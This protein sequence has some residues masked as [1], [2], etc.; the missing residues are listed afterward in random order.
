MSIIGKG[1]RDGPWYL[2]EHSVVRNDGQVD[3]LGRT[4]WAEWSHTGDLLFAMDG[5]IYRAQLKNSTLAPSEEA[6]KIADLSNL[7]FENRE[8]PYA[9][10]EWLRK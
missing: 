6:I 3:R 7:R 8:A 5:A 1:E 4:D 2:T 10:N 9:R